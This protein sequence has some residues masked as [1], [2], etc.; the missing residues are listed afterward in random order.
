MFTV[1][2]S[3]I[4]PLKEVTVRLVGTGRGPLPALG[5]PRRCALLL[6]GVAWMC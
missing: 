3:D 4:G 1:K 2:G 5:A 6:T